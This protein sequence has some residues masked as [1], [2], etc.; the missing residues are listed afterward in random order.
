MSNV[1]RSQSSCFIVFVL[2]PFFSTNI[3]LNL[4][5]KLSLRGQLFVFRKIIVQLGVVSAKQ[6]PG[7][8]TAKHRSGRVNLKGNDDS[9]L[10]LWSFF[11]PD[12]H[13]YR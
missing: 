9:K 8:A 3:S 2:H 4:G 1:L 10:K 11:S 5:P 13:S 7:G 12:V 6:H